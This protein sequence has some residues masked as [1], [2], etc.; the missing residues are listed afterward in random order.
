MNKQLGSLHRTF[1][2]GLE[3]FM[4]TNKRYNLCYVTPLTICFLIL[5]KGENPSCMKYR[6]TNHWIN[7]A[8]QACVGFQ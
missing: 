3:N 2:F 1:H 7:T 8:S 5:E 4:R 6:N